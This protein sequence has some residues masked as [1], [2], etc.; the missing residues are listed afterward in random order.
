MPHII[1]DSMNNLKTYFSINDV[2]EVLVHVIL[3]VKVV[4]YSW[5]IR[6]MYNL[7][8]AFKNKIKAVNIV[9]HTKL[10]FWIRKQID[11][12]LF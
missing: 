6:C 3:V 8:T 10:Y 11:A 2:V 12:L 5:F 9:N 7:S 4:I 1:F